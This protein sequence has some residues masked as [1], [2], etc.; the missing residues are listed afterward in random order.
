MVRSEEF[1]P[2]K[3]SPDSQV[4]SPNTCRV[5]LSN[6]HKIWIEIA[7]G[8]LEGLFFYAYDIFFPSPCSSRR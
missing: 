8:K 2:L 6:L 1:S 4:D 7:G 5:D 3:N